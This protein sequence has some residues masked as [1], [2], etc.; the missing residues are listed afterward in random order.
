MEEYVRMPPNPRSMPWNIKFLIALLSLQ[1][2][3]VIFLIVIIA[4]TTS[5][6]TEMHRSMAELSKMM[7]KVQLGME[8][9]SQICDKVGC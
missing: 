9:V 7:P 5:M 2:L 6:L 4:N 3:V 8:Q 1:A